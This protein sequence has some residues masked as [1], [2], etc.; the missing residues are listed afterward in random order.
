[1][2]GII[3]YKLTGHHQLSAGIISTAAVLFRPR[4]YR[5]QHRRSRFLKT[6][7][8]WYKGRDGL[9]SAIVLARDIVPVGGSR[10]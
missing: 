2:P 3:K 7:R 9:A 1:M 4:Q 6:I 10:G 5:P 8:G